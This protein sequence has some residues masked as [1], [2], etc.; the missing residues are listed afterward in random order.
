MLNFE[1]KI[2]VLKTYLEKEKGNYGDEM[3]NEIYFRFFE[4]E[5]DFKFLNDLHTK[6]EI[7]NKIELI[8][9]RMILH[10]HDDELQN[11]ISYQL[12]G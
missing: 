11:I 12:Y 5:C 3:K 6:Q 10:E 9:S 8:V 1:E 2:E 7:E 4:N